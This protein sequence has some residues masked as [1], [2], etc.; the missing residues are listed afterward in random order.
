M[1]AGSPEAVQSLEAAGE[2]VVT[3]G[4]Q[5]KPSASTYPI[6]GADNLATEVGRGGHP[7]RGRAP[8]S[9]SLPDRRS[10]PVPDH[11]RPLLPQQRKT[12]FQMPSWPASHHRGTQVSSKHL[13]AWG[14]HGRTEVTITS[15]IQGFCAGW[16]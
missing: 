6:A 13:K 12:S 9:A 16:H 8:A 3:D 15:L 11:H 14:P 2:Q 10:V 4:E 1:S 5:S 7:L